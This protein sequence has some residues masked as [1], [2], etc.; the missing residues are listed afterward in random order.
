MEKLRLAPLDTFTTSTS[1]SLDGLDG[2]FID[3][4]LYKVDIY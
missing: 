3:A 1:L 4:Y 2:Y